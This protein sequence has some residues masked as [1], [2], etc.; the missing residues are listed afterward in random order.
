MSFLQLIDVK[1]IEKRFL[2]RK[3][4]IRA[5]SLLRISAAWTERIVD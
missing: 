3:R 5:I 4:F 1:D 2:S